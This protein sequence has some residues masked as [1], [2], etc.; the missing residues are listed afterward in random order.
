MAPR[1]VC[2]PVTRPFS[3]SI[4][5]T[6]QFWIRSTP[7]WSAPREAP[8]D[9][10]VAR[11]SAAGL[12]EAAEDGETRLL[13]IEVGDDLADPLGIQKDRIIP[14]I[15]YCIS[16]PCIGV[17]LAVGVEQVDD[18]ALGMHHVVVEVGLE[19]FPE[20][21][22]M[23]VEFRVSGQAVVGADN[24]GV[25]AHVA[26]AKVALLQHRDIGKAMFFREIMRRG[27]PVT[28]AAD[29]DDVIGVARC[30]VAPGRAPALVPGQALG[31]HRQAGIPHFGSFAS[32]GSRRTHPV[33]ILYT[34]RAYAS[35]P[36]VIGCDVKH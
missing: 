34:R 29:D 35:P 4:P 12:V 26:A 18:A 25:P 14:L 27:Q 16:A 23:G 3:I 17:A 2:T 8:G 5:V 36:T 1:E 22:R 6:S 20:L 30:R 32:P 19:P 21:Q 33:H 11:G 24:G 28:A 15:S 31:E 7:R 10:V 9:G 13:E